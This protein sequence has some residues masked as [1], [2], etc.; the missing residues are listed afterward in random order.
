METAQ[1]SLNAT[2]V[3][4]NKDIKNR[5]DVETIPSIYLDNLTRW[6]SV[7]ANNGARLNIVF[8]NWGLEKQDPENYLDK[9]QKLIE[10]MCIDIQEYAKDTP[11]YENAKTKE[12]K[13]AVVKKIKNAINFE[14]LDDIKQEMKEDLLKIEKKTIESPEYKNATTEEQKSRIL[15]KMLNKKMFYSEE[16]L[17]EAEKEIRKIVFAHNE[18]EGIA[19]HLSDIRISELDFIFRDAVTLSSEN[20]TKNNIKK[21]SI[22]V[23][24]QFDYFVNCIKTFKGKLMSPA[25]ISN[26][27]KLYRVS[28][29]NSIAM[30]AGVLCPK[31]YQG[32]EFKEMKDGLYK[33]P[34]E[35]NSNDDRRLTTKRKDARNKEDP[36]LTSEQNINGS[37]LINVN[38]YEI[39]VDFNLLNYSYSK[40]ITTPEIE[41][42]NFT[43]D[44]GFGGMLGKFKT[45]FLTNFLDLNA[46]S[47]NR[48]SENSWLAN[49]TDKDCNINFYSYY[50]SLRHNIYEK[51]GKEEH[52]ERFKSLYQKLVK[53]EPKDI[54]TI[55]E[56]ED[57]KYKS[58]HTLESGELDKSF[59]GVDGEMFPEEDMIKNPNSKGFDQLFQD[60]LNFVCSQEDILKD[61]IRSRLKGVFKEVFKS[62]NPFGDFEEQEQEKEPKY[63]DPFKWRS[64]SNFFDTFLDSKKEQE[65]LKI[66]PE[67]NNSLKKMS[68]EETKNLD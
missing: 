64:Q 29:P 1:K 19:K 52:F 44:K 25:F 23:I 4:I 68:E 61:K 12:E 15:M 50:A 62:I 21:D 38:D 35:I 56:K 5:Y 16:K 11:A 58:E 8:E 45:I 13:N 6:A 67:I 27:V 39:G 60:K 42:S 66:L 51:N 49:K 34:I 24:E 22:D 36:L 54:K 43:L 31:K 3:W 20:K 26:I 53:N 28:K 9:R 47:F 2:S 65:M 10:A 17:Q 55:F 30:D 37:F 32:L 40:A 18:Y 46:L 7:F 33:F 63:L 59:E 57:R 48:I 41:S 14:S